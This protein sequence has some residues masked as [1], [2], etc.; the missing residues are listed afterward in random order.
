MGWKDAPVVDGE[1]GGGATPTGKGWKSAPE[2]SFLDR[3]GRYARGIVDQTAQ[4]LTLGFGDEIGAA[5]DAA[6]ESV[7][8]NLGG[9]ST[10]PTWNQRYNENLAAERSRM[11]QFEKE[12]PIAATIANIGGGVLGAVNLPA[13]LFSGSTLPAT[14]AK[15]VGAGG[16]LGGTTAFGEGEGGFDKRAS[17]NMLIG[18]G[19]GAGLGAAAP[20][21]AAG[22]GAAFNKAAPPILRKVADKADDFAAKATPDNLSAAAPEGGPPITQDGLMARVA[23]SARNTAEGIEQKAAISRL[24]RELERSGGVDPARMRLAE[25]GDNAFIADT[26][27][28]ARRLAN[29][30]YI[31]PGEAPEKYKAALNARN[32]G[33]SE[34]VQKVFEGSEPPPTSYELRGDGQAFDQHARAVGNRAYGDM[35]AAGIKQT[36]ELMALYENPF[37]EA[38][39]NQ[40]MTVEKNARI[41]RPEA[42]PSSPIEIMHKVKQKIWDMGFDAKTARP[43]ADASY[44]RDLGTDFVDKLKSANPALREADELYTAAKSLPEYFDLGRDF[45]ARG[46]GERATNASAAGLD[47]RLGKASAEQVLAARTGATNAV[48]ETADTAQ[49]AIATAKRITESDTLQA[50]LRQLYGPERS[51]EIVKRLEAERAFTETRNEVMG[52]SRTAQREASIGDEMLSIPGTGHSAASIWQSMANQ[53]N[54]LRQPNEI[55]RKRLADLLANPNEALNAET[56]GLVEAAIKGPG[57]GRALSTGASG[58]TGGQT[59]GQF[60]P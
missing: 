46:S 60:G 27:E 18:A 45:M 51:A 21:V 8:L 6:A 26:S 49:S 15:G 57:A 34:R 33:T 17:W 35:D 13:K 31:L 43:G 22:A 55:M 50:K 37:V 29:L 40:V 16:V 7:G 59:P 5:V 3:A 42:I 47:D 24:A 56:L 9:A 2:A 28:G 52:G 58:A 19:A 4:G 25:L 20:L 30:G 36:P 39:M 44:Y 41:G 10:A 32:R 48:R 1:G 12:N 23:D 38:A 14:I 53:Y 54:K 11:G